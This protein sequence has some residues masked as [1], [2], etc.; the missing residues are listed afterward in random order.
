MHLFQNIKGSCQRAQISA[1]SENNSPN[2]YRRNWYRSNKKI[3]NLQGGKTAQQNR[4]LKE[5]QRKHQDGKQLIQTA[6]EDTDDIRMTDA[7][8]Q[9]YGQDQSSISDE[10][11]EYS[12]SDSIVPVQMRVSLP[13]LA[14]VADRFQIVPLLA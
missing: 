14:R 7:D 1:W 9:Q 5:I 8:E 3:K 2:V 6:T 12:D 4:D 10:G 11:D 13:N